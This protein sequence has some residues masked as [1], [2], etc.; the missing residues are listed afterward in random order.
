MAVEMR[1]RGGQLGKIGDD[2]VPDLVPDG[3]NAGHLDA[4]HAL[5]EIAVGDGEL[6]QDFLVLDVH[7]HLDM[8]VGA[9]FPFGAEEILAEEIGPHV[10]IVGEDAVVL[11][12]IDAGLR[13]AAAPR[14]PPMLMEATV[15]R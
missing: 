1:G 11:V 9:P 13:R 8:V 12:E 15:A 2:I 5:E 6:R 3:V 7:L 14:P 4:A 10:A